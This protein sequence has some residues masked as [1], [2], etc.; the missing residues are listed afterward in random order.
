MKGLGVA[1]TVRRVFAVGLPLLIGMPLASAAVEPGWV[2][3]EFERRGH[4]SYQLVVDA[5]EADALVQ[6]GSGWRRTGAVLHAHGYPEGDFNVPVCRVSQGDTV[7]YAVGSGGCP[8]VANAYGVPV[9]NVFYLAKAGAGG[10]C[11]SGERVWSLPHPSNP[12]LHARIGVGE[13]VPGMGVAKSQLVWG[14]CAPKTSRMRRMEAARLLDQATFG[15]TPSAIDA[16]VSAAGVRRWVADQMALP[17]TRYTQHPT[18]YRPNGF[19]DPNC[20][21]SLADGTQA[22]PAVH[23]CAVE[24]FSPELVQREFFWQATESADQLR[25]RVAWAWSQLFVVS[26]VKE[27]MAYGMADYQQRLRDLAFGRFEDLL[28]MVSTHPMMGRMLDNMGN[29][30]ASGSRGPNENFARE[31]LQ[32]FTTGTVRLNADGSPV[33]GADGL[34]APLYAQDTVSEMARAVTGWV[35]AP[36]SPPEGRMR[37]NLRD[38]MVPNANNHDTGSKRLFGGEL[39][40]PSG[41]DAEAELRRVVRFLAEHPNTAVSVSRYLV[42]RLVTSNPSGAYLERVVGAFRNNGNGVVGDLGAVVTAILLDPEA[43]G[44]VRPEEHYGRL[45]DNVQRYVGLLR[46]IDARG[47]KG[48]EVQLPWTMN[49]SPFNAP[50][51]FGFFLADHQV[52]PGLLGPEFNANRVSTVLDWASKSSS[53]VAQDIQNWN[54]STPVAG[55]SSVSGYVTMAGNVGMLIDHLN[56]T[57]AAGSMSAAMNDAMVSMLADFRPW[58][59]TPDQEFLARSALFLFFNSAQY[60]VQR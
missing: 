15:A 28:Y 31:L 13:P 18:Y 42:Q 26:S 10:A 6:P 30:K 29:A 46:A 8:Q 1:R 49:A 44:A 57:Y 41:L 9:P 2:A 27:G 51:V 50:S 59:S 3:A 54:G 21:F 4:P 12:S 25:Q 14:L 58:N 43:R 40:I 5:R 16:V 55:S 45:R 7:A 52:V 35:E 39:V 34:P 37:G 22:P 24:T 53:L 17:A 48:Q 23:R 32:L 19:F 36:S 11:A 33:L 56:M 38:P 60:H 47:F 20:T